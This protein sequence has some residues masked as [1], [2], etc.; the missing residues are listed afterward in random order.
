[1]T[2][3]QLIGLP[4]LSSAG[5]RRGYVLRAY[6]TK[7][8]TK[9]TCLLCVDEDEEEFILP[10]RAIRAVC[11]A[12]IASGSALPEA[13]GSPFPI[14]KT[15]YSARGESLGII[16]D[17][18]LDRQ[19]LLAYNEKEPLTVPLPSLSIGESVVLRAQQ[20]PRNSPCKRENAAPPPSPQP[21]NSLYP[22]NLL[23]RTAKK[24]LFG[25]DGLIVQSGENITPSVLAAARKSGKLL[26]LSTII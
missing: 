6:G 1:M 8:A 14:G 26:E 15:L 18:D 13:V 22:G 20:P 21:T 11:D 7:R 16:C 17:V 10:A 2:V 12:V 24:S 4:V 3:S 23:G 9:L 19:V 25:C 5:T